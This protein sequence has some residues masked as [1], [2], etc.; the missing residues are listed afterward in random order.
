MVSATAGSVFCDQPD[1][2]C[3]HSSS[4]LKALSV[5]LSWP[6]SR[7]G[8]YASLIGSNPHRFKGDKGDELPSQRTLLSVQ[9]LIRRKTSEESAFADVDTNRVILCRNHARRRHVS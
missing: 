7:H 5:N 2:D 6:S 3:W 9:N 8:L 4:R 1:Q